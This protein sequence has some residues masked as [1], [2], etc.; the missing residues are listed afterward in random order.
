MVKFS[1]KGLYKRL[2]DFIK[3]QSTTLIKGNAEDFK[4]LNDNCMPL[5]DHEEKLFY[6]FLTTHF[7][8]ADTAQNIY[9]ELSWEKLNRESEVQIRSICRRFLDQA[10]QIGDH[11]RY[12]RCLSRTNKYYYT[13][14]ALK[15]YKTEVNKVTVRP[16]QSNY[17]DINGNT[18][19]EQL[20]EK[21]GGIKSFHTRLPRWDHLER[22]FRIYGHPRPP[23]T[24][25]VED[26]TGPLDGLTYLIVGSRY[27]KDKETKEIR[28]YLEG[29][30]I[31]DWNS[32]IGK[33]SPYFVES[34][35]FR[36]VVRKLELWLINEVKSN[37]FDLET[38]LCNWQKNKKEGK[39]CGS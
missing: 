9:R 10:P 21:M 14:E 26:S 11:R 37:V 28:H 13:W 30:F 39:C 27:K 24:I 23:K 20:Y 15:S 12:F 17:F 2:K 33:G 31:T 32:F 19:F 29:S 7:D 8:S 18:T 16:H 5:K 22:I 35:S 36:D 4:S 3:D 38:C 1:R 6:I 34:D 25:F